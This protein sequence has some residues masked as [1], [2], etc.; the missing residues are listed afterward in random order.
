MSQHPYADFP[1]D[2]RVKSSRLQPFISACYRPAL[3][4]LGQAYA[5]RRPGAVLVGAG[6]VGPRMVVDEFLEKLDED[7]T[8]VRVKGPCPDA[9][10]CMR[11]IV[12]EVGFEP[13]RMGLGDLESVLEMFLVYQRTKKQRDG[14]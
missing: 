12:N 11:Q 2:I 4:Q 7:V 8:V 14:H 5:E 1:P 3:Q 10:T 13:A 6:Q 9:T